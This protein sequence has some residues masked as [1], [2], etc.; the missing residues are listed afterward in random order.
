M[1]SATKKKGRTNDVGKYSTEQAA[2]AQ[3]IETLGGD[4]AL[5]WDDETLMGVNVHAAL[6]SQFAKAGGF[7][8]R[9]VETCPMRLTSNNA[10][11]VRD[12][13]ATVMVSM[14]NG[15]TRFRHFDRLRGDTATAELFGV[16]RFM[17]CD[18]V[19]RN[20]ASIPAEEA[21]PWVWRE[22]LRLL[23]DVVSEDYVL[24]LD[25]TVKPVYGRQEGAQLGYSPQKPGRPSHCY[26][27]LCIAKL[28]L[29]L[30]VV[31]HHAWSRPR[32]MVFARR[33]VEAVPK[34]R[35]SPPTRKFTQLGIPGLELVEASDRA[36]ADGYER[37]ALVTDLDMDARDVLP[38][39]AG[40]AT[41][42]TSSTR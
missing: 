18:S 28:R 2:G 27:T 33:P 3:R 37:Y 34:R 29:T 42:R 39:A 30:A 40:A 4:Y 24:D 25:P 26:H 8:D 15:A 6:L 10:P 14:I 9:L 36:C 5:K 1:L 23:Q 20:F 7:L 13:I 32:R 35:K 22:N 21:M 38:P 41:A 16:R 19:R 11:E 17:S 12:L 31:V